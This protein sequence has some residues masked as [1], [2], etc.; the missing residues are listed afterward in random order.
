M[1]RTR[2]ISLDIRFIC[3]GVKPM[4]GFVPD[5][6]DWTVSQWTWQTVWSLYSTAGDAPVRRSAGASPTCPIVI[7]RLLGSTAST[8]ISCFQSAKSAPRAVRR[9][10]TGG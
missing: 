9:A 3:P 1:D 6:F 5:R 2:N 4:A 8:A 10:S 7:D